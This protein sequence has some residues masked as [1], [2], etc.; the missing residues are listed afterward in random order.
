[1]VGDVEAGSVVPPLEGQRTGFLPDSER[2]R[3]PLTGVLDCILQ[4]LQTAEVDCSLHLRRVASEVDGVQLSWDRATAACRRECL[5]QPTVTQKRGI[6][7]VGQGAKFLQRDLD[8]PLQLL[9]ESPRR[10]RIRLLQL[11]DQPG[12]YRDGDE[13]LLGSVVE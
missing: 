7:A 11:P 5:C 8:V 4:C 2:G 10:R 3:G 13:V 12:L 9:E 6:D 1:M